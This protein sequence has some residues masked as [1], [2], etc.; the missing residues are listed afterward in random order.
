MG[1][2]A[3]TSGELA[4]RASQRLSH[5]KRHARIP[6]VRYS[7]GY[8]RPRLRAHDGPR[9]LRCSYE[10]K[11][12]RQNACNSSGT[13][14]ARVAKR[15]P[16]PRT[17]ACSS[18]LY[19]L[20]RHST[21]GNATAPNLPRLSGVA[22]VQTLRPRSACPPY[23]HPPASARLAVKMGSGSSPAPLARAPERHGGAQPSAGHPPLASAVVRIGC[24]ISEKRSWPIAVLTKASARIASDS[25]PSICSESASA[26]S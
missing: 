3:R 24:T 17:G 8:T 5:F 4:C 12:H 13:H 1:G 20:M 11:K 14:A 6:R 25:Y 22:L 16:L 7:G 10:R 18:T 21:R 15:P 9:R 2:K 23:S 19:R 26:S